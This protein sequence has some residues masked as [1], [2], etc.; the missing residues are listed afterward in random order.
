LGWHVFVG[1]CPE[2]GQVLLNFLTD[3]LLRNFPV[4]AEEAAQDLCCAA[5]PLR[6]GAAVVVV[7]FKVGA[8]N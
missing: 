3:P 8:P 5:L 2:E 6:F 4:G 7:G 1:D